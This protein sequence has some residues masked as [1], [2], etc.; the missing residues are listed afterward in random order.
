MRPVLRPLQHLQRAM[1]RLLLRLRPPQGLH[2]R[3]VVS[4]SLR[5]LLCSQEEVYE[6]CGW[7]RRGWRGDCCRACG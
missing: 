4:L 2:L 7:R 3:A 5:V 1:V 6:T